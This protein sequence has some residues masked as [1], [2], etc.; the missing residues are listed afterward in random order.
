MGLRRRGAVHR[1]N[2]AFGFGMQHK[3]RM[4]FGLVWFGL[5][6]FSWFGL[7]WCGVWFSWF[8]LVGLVWV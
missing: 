3:N 6:G 8:G 7:A 4:R 5:L 2:S 1:F